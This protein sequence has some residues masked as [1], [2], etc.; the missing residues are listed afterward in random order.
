ML[1]GAGECSAVF[2]AAELKDFSSWEFPAAARWGRY[3]EKD[4]EYNNLLVSVQAVWQIQGSVWI[5]AIA[6]A[7]GVFM[8][9]DKMGITTAVKYAYIYKIHIEHTYMHI[10]TNAYVHLLC[11]NK[12]LVSVPHLPRGRQQP[13][14]TT[15]HVK[16][17]FCLTRYFVHNQPGLAWTLLLLNIKWKKSLLGTSC[18]DAGCEEANDFSY[19]EAAA[20]CLW[21]L[22]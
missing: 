17:L 8:I 15:L 1:P 3:Q 5:E 19:S 7:N 22:H 11:R 4:V 18:S 13:A 9:N 16:E 10:Y 6:V 20:K 12:H 2:S 21:S 14:G